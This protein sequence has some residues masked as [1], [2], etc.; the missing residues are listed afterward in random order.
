MIDAGIALVAENPRDIAIGE[1]PAAE[2]MP[3]SVQLLGD[4]ASAPTDIRPVEDLTDDYGFILYD[5]ELLSSF[6]PVLPRR[7]RA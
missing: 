3:T 5:R 6:L 1:L 4:P 2:A 7:E